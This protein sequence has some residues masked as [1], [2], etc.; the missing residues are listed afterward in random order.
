MN[1]EGGNQAAAQSQQQAEQ[2]LTEAEREAKEAGLRAVEAEKEA[3]EAQAA[4]AKYEADLEA[5]SSAYTSLEAHAHDL[6]TQKDGGGKAL[7]AVGAQMAQSCQD[8][9]QALL[10]RLPESSCSISLQQS[11]YKAF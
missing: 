4:A 6:E 1:G 10:T 2:R 5:L 8:D 3:R 9:P 11:H 7:P